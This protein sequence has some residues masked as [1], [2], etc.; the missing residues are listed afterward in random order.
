[1]LPPTASRAAVEAELEAARLW[2]ARHN[3]TL[4][5]L[6]DALMLRA[7]TYHV[8]AC[9]VVEFTAQCGGYRAIPLL[10]KSV[11]PG[12]DETEAQWFPKPGPGSIFHGNLIICAP[13]S[14]LA[15]SDHDG[16]H[17]DWGG[18]GAWLQVG[19]ASS[20]ARTIPDMLATI[21]AHLRQSPGMFA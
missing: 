13:W 21:D 8:P 14:R 9:R 6:P 16:P 12:T 18:P 1:M 4:L 15:Y 10:W 5:W 3:W 20:I 2:S 17:N 11:R 7:A 19:G